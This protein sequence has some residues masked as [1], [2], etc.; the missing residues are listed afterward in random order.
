MT[1]CG[2]LFVLISTTRTQIFGDEQ[3]LDDLDGCHTPLCEA[4]RERLEN[5]IDQARASL[6]QLEQQ[7]TPICNLLMGTWRVDANGSDGQLTIA[8]VDSITG[9]SLKGTVKFTD[10][11]A[12]DD[13]EGSWDDTAKIIKFRLGPHNPV[14]QDY[15]G[16]LGD[17]HADQFVILAGSFTESD[18]PPGTPRSQFGWFARKP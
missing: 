2:E 18:I 6:Q 16:F 14:F 7:V 8:H 5:D 15:T 12:G 3:A 10:Q 11:A 17:N 4:R 1:D 13:I 9:E